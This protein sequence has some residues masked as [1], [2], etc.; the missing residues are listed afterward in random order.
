VVHQERRN[1]KPLEAPTGSRSSRT[2]RSGG[3]KWENRSLKSASIDK[4]N[5]TVV[6]IDVRNSDLGEVRDRDLDNVNV[7]IDRNVNRTDINLP[8]TEVNKDSQ[9]IIPA[10]LRCYYANVDTLTNKFQEFYTVIEQN[11]P[12]LIFITEVKAKH[13][14]TALTLAELQVE[15]YQSPITNISEEGTRGIC[16]YI[17]QGLMAQE[18]EGFANNTFSESVWINL[19]LRDQETLLAGCI[20]R[21][22]SSE[23]ANNDKMPELLKLVA[24]TN[25]SHKLLVGD[26]N[27]PGIDWET[28]HTDEGPGQL[29][30]EFIKCIQDTFLI[31]HRI[32]PTRFREGQRPS[33][34]DLILTNEKDMYKELLD[35]P[36]LG[37]SDHIGQVFGFTCYATNCPPK[38]PKPRYDKGN[39]CAMREELDQVDWEAELADLGIEE[40]LTFV[41]NKISGS[42]ETHIPYSN[43]K[44][45]KRRSIWM[46]RTAMKKVKRKY[47]AWKRYL[48]TKDGED[49]CRYTKE[50]DE[51]RSITRKLS[52][53]YEKDLAKNIK[54]NPKAFW[55][56]VNSKTKVRGGIDDLTKDDGTTA[57]SDEDK[58][59]TL[60]DFF[61]S[62]FTVEDLNTIPDIDPYYTGD[63]PLNDFKTTPDQ[64]YKKLAKL[65][66]DKAAG[67][68]GM[69]PRVL[70][71]LAPV[72]STPLSIVF[73]KSLEAGQLPQIWKEA[74]V[75]PLHKK[76]SKKTPGN[77]RPISLTSVVGKLLES[78]VRDQ[79][80]KHMTDNNLFTEDQH[81]FVPGRSC[82]TQLLVVLDTWTRWLD[83]GVPIDTAYLDFSK[84]FDSVP[85]ER[86]LRKVEAHGIRGETLQWLRNFLS[87]RKQRVQV[88]GKMSDWNP[89][90][91]GIPQG[92]VL[93]PTLFVIFINDLPLAVSGHTKIF[94][95]DTKLYHQVNSVQGVTSMQEDLDSLINWSNIWQ[96]KFNADKC[97]ILHLGHKNTNHQYTMKSNNSQTDLKSTTVEKDLGVHVDDHLKFKKHTSTAVAKANQILGIIKRSF[98]CCDSDS[99]CRLYKTMVRPH[100]EYANA[101]WGPTS[102]GD[103]D[104]IESV[105]RRATR[106]IPE[107]KDLPYEDRLRTLNLPS[108]KYR[109]VRGDMIQTFKIIKGI[110]RINPDDMFLKCQSGTT[111]GHSEKLMKSHCRTNLRLKFFSNRVIS[112]WNSLPES[113]IQCKSVLDFKIALDNFWQH[114][115]FQNDLSEASRMAHT[116][117]NVKKCSDRGTT[118]EA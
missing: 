6:D 48:A 41:N 103:S 56:Y 73:N 42:M 75:T 92:S 76:G 118:G 17:K 106:M 55:K 72:I 45:D 109:R 96:L 71:E 93:G 57:S 83:E 46:N 108:M 84:A 1:I 107:V 51:L 80:V 40:A 9:S 20:Y 22:P 99:V 54:T 19:K 85:H 66:S 81:G 59:Q 115:F 32:K 104:S 78:L 63:H 70:K 111:R 44:K 37:S 95:D 102:K 38:L 5:C 33:T 117:V 12:D 2:R 39:Y 77:Y 90:T 94:A 64:V 7:D 25:H 114:K 13:C 100:L 82:V 74:T 24:N 3:G 69:H 16:I 35:L 21:S 65:K 31:Q 86:L 43:P 116:N 30:F 97:K 50:R 112:D 110:D 68:D 28:Q 18:Y 79:I 101:A 26:F 91:S 52:Y 60:N 8:V 61:S 34:L 4:E 14:S 53:D 36:P 98:T 23:Q 29:G 67:P 49:Y 15:G 105:Q 62:V 47:H 10:Q 87:G 88:N 113:V 89:V 27:Q 11:Q 58:A